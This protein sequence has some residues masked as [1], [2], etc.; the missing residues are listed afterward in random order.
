[1]TNDR[2]DWLE[3]MSVLRFEPGDTIILKCLH[4]V[5]VE[6]R[7]VIE[8]LVSERLGAPVMLLDDGV[9]IGVLRPAA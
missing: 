5:T 1:M 2:P 4:R 9:E 6:Q 3:A 7:K 8:E